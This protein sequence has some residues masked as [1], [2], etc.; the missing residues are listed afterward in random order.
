MRA[1][2][3]AALVVTGAH[4][5]PLGGK[6]IGWAPDGPLHQ[7]QAE[8]VAT[9]GHPQAAQQVAI[10][11]EGAYMALSVRTPCASLLAEA[12]DRAQQALRNG[13]ESLATQWRVQWR[14]Y[15]QAC[16]LIRADV[17]ASGDLITDEQFA[18]WQAAK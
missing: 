8:A 16:E 6:H 17:I 9:L 4:A 7:Y 15:T 14:Y 3:L 11:S 5:A 1:L 13:D 10:W 2:I 12:D 18:K